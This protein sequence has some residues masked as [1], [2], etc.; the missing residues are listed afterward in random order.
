MS[1]I[2]WSAR[3]RR[4][5]HSARMHR[6]TWIDDNEPLP[7]TQRRWVRTATR[8]ACWRPAAGVTPQRLERGL[9]AGYRS[10]GSAP[11]SRCCGGAPTRAWCCRWRS[12]Q[13]SKSL[14]KTLRRFRAHSP[15]ASV[16]IDSAFARVIEACA[17]HA[18]GRAGRHLDR[19]VD[20]GGLHRMAPAGRAC[21]ASRPGSTVE[22]VG[23]LYCVAIGRMCLRRIDVRAGHR[24]LEDGAGRAGGVLPRTRRR[25]ASTASRTPRHLA[26]LGAHEVSRAA[27]EQHLAAGCCGAGDCRLD[28]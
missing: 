5:C 6:P 10:R 12:F 21:T 19:A 22:L 27:F 23:G 1:S 7:P 14:R 16:R 3:R 26:S 18:A 8:R 17:Q 2:W 4:G 28:L 15:A 13:V 25:A 9:P 11:A 20:G 24:R